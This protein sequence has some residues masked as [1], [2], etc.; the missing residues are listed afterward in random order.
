MLLCYNYSNE[1]E[2][3][4]VTLLDSWSK[5]LRPDIKKNVTRKLMNLRNVLHASWGEAHPITGKL[6]DQI[7]KGAQSRNVHSK[8]GFEEMDLHLDSGEPFI[9]W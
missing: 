9:H 1:L 7:Y 8:N 3:S 4:D 6:S 5:A 2:L